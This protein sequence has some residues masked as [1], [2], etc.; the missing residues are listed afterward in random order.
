MY[1]VREIPTKKKEKYP[2]QFESQEFSRL[3]PI[4]VINRTRVAYLFSSP[5][6]SSRFI[7]T[8]CRTQLNENNTIL[9]AF[10]FSGMFL[11]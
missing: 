5:E 6:A 10:F 1:Y 7:S 3:L 2:E 8:P 4:R 9:F 11:D